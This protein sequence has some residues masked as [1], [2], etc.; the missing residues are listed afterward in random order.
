[1]MHRG[2]YGY[3]QCGQK[4]ASDPLNLELRA[5]VTPTATQTVGAEIQSLVLMIVQ[6]VLH[7]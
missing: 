7:C 5:F 2:I 4:R 3:T 6:Q 1:M